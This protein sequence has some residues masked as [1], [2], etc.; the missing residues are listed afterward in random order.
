MT[1]W[2]DR[3]PAGVPLAYPDYI[4]P[5]YMVFAT[6]A[7]LDYRRRTGKG[8]Y[9]DVSQL[10]TSLQFLAPALLDYTV[11]GR[12]QTRNGNRSSVAPHGA[13]QCKGED[14][15]C[16]IAVSTDRQ[17]GAFRKVMGKPGW[18][19]QTR[20]EA[21]DGRLN[22]EAEL[23]KYIEA[24]TRQYTAEEVMRLLQAAGVPA[25]VVQNG[26]DIMNDPQLEHRQHFRR[27][28]HTEIGEHLCEMPP[29]RFSDTPPE[30]GAPFPS[31]GEHNELVCSKILGL[32]DQEFSEL[33]AEGVLA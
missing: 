20:F 16:T 1:G 25:G 33:I 14:R 4:T 24:W 6:M 28:E 7:A 32:S 15:W 3:P 5:W 12:I 13:Y 27:L 26:Q 21:A 31:L 10:E 11:N 23:D 17:W 18:A 29:A 19:M 8:L 2:P 9:L 22:H 30:F